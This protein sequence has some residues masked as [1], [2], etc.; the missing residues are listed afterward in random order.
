ML[1]AGGY[2][3]E[4]YKLVAGSVIRLIEEGDY[5]ERTSDVPGAIRNAPGAK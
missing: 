2:T 5:A 1:L 3:R 4:S